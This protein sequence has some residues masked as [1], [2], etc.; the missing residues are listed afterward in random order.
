MKAALGTLPAGDGWAFELKWDGVRLQATTHPPD[1]HRPL[2]LRSISARDVT[3]HYPELAT[4]RDAV[5]TSAVLDGEVVVFDGD[6]PSFPRLQHRMHVTD[7][8]PT[9]VTTHPVVFIVFDLLALDGN[10]LLD[11]P[12]ETRRRLLT[13]LVDD[14]PA[15]R[16]PPAST[17]SGQAL[18]DLARER[19]LEGVV[20]KRLDSRYEPGARSKQWIKI[21]VRRQQEFVVGGWLPGQGALTGSIGSLLIGVHHDGRFVCAGAVGSGLTDGDRRR[22]QAVLTPTDDCPFDPVPEVDRPPRWVEPERVVEV[23]Y[24]EWPETGNIRHPV[25]LGLRTDHDPRDV[26]RELPPGEEKMG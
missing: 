5:S 16:V 15:W 17:G 26:V 10:S 12:Y 23:G 1:E 9:L 22:L 11:L 20:A 14:G 6:R 18:V 25:Y 7:P 19:G 24:G 3:S 8:L 4:L 2:T 13:E 21:K